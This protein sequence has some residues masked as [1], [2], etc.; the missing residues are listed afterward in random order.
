MSAAAVVVNPAARGGAAAIAAEVAERLRRVYAPVDVL[1]TRAA[2]DGVG[3][4]RD[5]AQAPGTALVVAVGGDGTA[6]EV[7]QGIA[8]GLGTWSAQVTGPAPPGAPQ[9]LLVPAGTGN[10]LHRAV[11][12]DRP[13]QDTLDLLD[14]GATVRRDLDLAR[15]EGHDCA[16][17]LGASAGLLRWAVEA[18]SRFP[19][20]A[21]REL[22]AAAGLAAAQELRPFAGR[23]CVDGRVLCEGPLALA[24][25]G[26]AP[27][28]GGSL[29]I[30]PRSR[31]DD[32]LLDVCV[33]SA[34]N[35]EEAMPLLM[36]AMAGSHLDRPGV[37]YTQ[38][39]SVTLECLDAPLPFEH[40]GDLWEGDDR[41]LTLTVVPAAV[42]VV[43][44]GGSRPAFSA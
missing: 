14:R 11:W 25:L 4:A 10:S 43:A 13:W 33:L 9:L 26:G 5:A 29:E 30:L 39:R 17:L 37:H 27:H 6:R 2:G 28:R 32:G 15:V 3:L 23:V 38:G 16:V 44:P 12:G 24:A 18:T 34:G 36:L 19:E 41:R 21:G 7:A 31:L 8:E 22:Y 42:P 35:A 40:D 1:R 20:L